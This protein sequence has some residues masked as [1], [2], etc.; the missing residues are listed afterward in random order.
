MMNLGT[1]VVRTPAISADSQFAPVSERNRIPRG[2]C[3]E[4]DS[5]HE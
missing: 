2:A 4:F 5:D 3:V 1:W